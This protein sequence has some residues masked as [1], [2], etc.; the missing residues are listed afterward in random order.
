MSNDLISKK[1]AIKVVK[2]I[3]QAGL[4]E[5]AI[6]AELEEIPIAYDVD[7]VIDELESVKRKLSNCWAPEDKCLTTECTDCA[8]EKAIEIVRNGGNKK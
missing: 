2:T 4:T 6:Y 8:L 1:E 7:T 3:I 5:E